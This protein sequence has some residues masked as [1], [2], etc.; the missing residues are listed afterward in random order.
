MRGDLC[1]SVEV[2]CVREVIGVPTHR[3]SHSE[4]TTVTTLVE[5]AIYRIHTLIEVAIP[6]TDTSRGTYTVYRH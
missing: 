6:Y 3:L 5:V 1:D 4:H 2:G